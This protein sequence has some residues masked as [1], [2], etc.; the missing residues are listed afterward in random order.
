MRPGF[1]IFGP[2]DVLFSYETYE[3]VCKDE[4]F[5][6]VNKGKSLNCYSYVENL[7]DGLILVSTHPKAVG[8]T[9]IISDGP[10]ITYREFMQN[11]FESC[12][13]ELKLTSAPYWLGIAGATLLEAIYKLFRRKNGP[14]ITRYRVHVASSNLGFKNDKI[15]DEL[16][17]EARINLQDACKKTFDWFQLKKNNISLTNK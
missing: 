8:K 5:F 11:I 12:G 7:V 3:R 9:Y 17:Y 16:G 13:L 10:I 2:R 4:K 15:I 14:I 1:I 6:C